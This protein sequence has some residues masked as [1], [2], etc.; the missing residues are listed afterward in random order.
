MWSLADV[1]ELSEVAELIC[2]W[3]EVSQRAIELISHLCTPKRHCSNIVGSQATTTTSPGAVGNANE[4]S[5]HSGDDGRLLL[6]LIP[7][8]LITEHPCYSSAS[9][10][11]CTAS[12]AANNSNH[13]LL[14]LQSTRGGRYGSETPGRHIL[15]VRN[16]CWG[17]IN[18]FPW[19]AAPKPRASRPSRHDARSSL[20]T[21]I[22]STEGNHKQM[23]H[24]LAKSKVIYLS[25]QHSIRITWARHPSAA[26]LW[27]VRPL[28]FMTV[29]NWFVFC[30]IILRLFAQ[31]PIPYSLWTEP[32]SS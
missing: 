18:S 32:R 27:L 23:R 15:F 17:L 11:S 8:H 7:F 25:R 12:G 9:A 30:R 19:P 6:L 24:F 16:D 26:Y 3:R 21:L 1:E 22:S 29:S 31:Q 2:L 10:P 13:N 14:R 5:S 20:P 28:W 4:G